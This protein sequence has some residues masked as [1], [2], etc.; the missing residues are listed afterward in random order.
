M[1]VLVLQVV[2]W[3][4]Q[5]VAVP[6][7]EW[8]LAGAWRAVQRHEAARAKKKGDQPTEVRQTP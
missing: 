5:N 1:P 7:L 4:S 8:L 6:V 3:T 2:A